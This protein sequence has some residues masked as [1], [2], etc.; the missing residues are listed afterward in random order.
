MSAGPHRAVDV[1]R[2]VCSGIRRP[3]ERNIGPERPKRIVGRAAAF[4]FIGV[5]LG[6]CWRICS[7]FPV[8]FFPPNV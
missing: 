6:E 7:V 4:I 3:G 2:E 1:R 5:L 8:D